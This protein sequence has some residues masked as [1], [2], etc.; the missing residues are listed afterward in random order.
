MIVLQ[1]PDSIHLIDWPF[2]NYEL[3]DTLSH[4]YV[5]RRGK[6]ETVQYVPVLDACTFG[7]EA[8]V[9]EV[10]CSQIFVTKAVSPFSAFRCMI[11]LN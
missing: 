10:G 5:Q 1:Q 9:P 6:P 8:Q 2:P 4:S 3:T 11:T 7:P